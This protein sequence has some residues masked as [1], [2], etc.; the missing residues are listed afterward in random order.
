MSGAV[1]VSGT[2]RD[3]VGPCVVN[4]VALV[5]GEVVVVERSVVNDFWL[6]PSVTDVD[7][8]F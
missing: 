7:S 3:V 2:S 1:V 4:A 8:Y 6:L 5:V